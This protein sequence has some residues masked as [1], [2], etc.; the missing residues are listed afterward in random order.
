MQA[1]VSPNG[2]K[3]YFSLEEAVSMLPEI[4][5]ALRKAHAEVN[6]LRDDAILFKRVLI[7]RQ[8]NGMKPLEA[9]VTLL[10]E[11]FEAFEQICTRWV[12]Y[13]ADQGI[14]LRNLETG[15]MDF[16][17]RSRR[18]NQDYLLCWR[19][20]EDGIFYFHSISDGFSGRHPISLLPD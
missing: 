8:E 14:I 7:A 1:P 15:L 10:H 3:R 9:E 16:P 12:S 6:E 17:Y 13:F 11:K 2:F 5:R 18:T 19:L 20:E 4:E